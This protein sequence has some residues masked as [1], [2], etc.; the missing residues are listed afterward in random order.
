MKK[1]LLLPA[2]LA[3]SLA[4]LHATE[5]T[6]AS[7]SSVSAT[8]TAATDDEAE[9]AKQI[10][11]PVAALISVPFQ[12]NEDFGIG[13]AKGN[14]YTLNIQPVIPIS[15]NKD[16]NL[17]VRTIL[18]I[19][20]QN[21]VYGHSGSQ[22]GLGDTTQSFFLSPK[23]P[24]FGSLI[25]GV[26]PV[27]YYPTA[28][29]DLLGGGKF[30]MGPTFV[31]LNQTKGWTIGVL[32]NQIWSVAGDPDRQN[33][34]TAFI[35]PFISYTTKTYTSFT[36]NT[37]ST[38]DFEASQWTVPLNLMVSQVFKIGGQ[39]MS[40]QVGARYYADGPTGHPEWGMRVNFSL[41]FPLHHET[42]KEL[43]TAQK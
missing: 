13:S 43:E 24:L 30:G 2:L 18:P 3:F 17:I 12:S 28:T 7:A 19:I 22:T 41:L 21:D 40:L 29:N 34:S 42:P 35:Q 8:T 4:P 33:I 10:N 1:L 32:A 6:N 14:K 25:V 36:I 23:A 11:N 39:P 26:G 31:V 15:L 9:L 5:P 16:W 20:S 38:Y 27:M 37:E